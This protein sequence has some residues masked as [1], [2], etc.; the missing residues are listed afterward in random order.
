MIDIETLSL[1]HHSSR[2]L[3]RDRHQAI[4]IVVVCRMEVFER[5]APLTFA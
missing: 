1:P 5:E 4:R 3:Q 2:Q